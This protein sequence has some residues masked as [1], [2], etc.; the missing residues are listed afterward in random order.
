M[1]EVLRKQAADK[2]NPPLTLEQLLD[3]LA[4]SVPGFIKDVRDY[5]TLLDAKPGA[6]A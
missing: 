5:L 4:W 3:G 1:L 6:S 2:K